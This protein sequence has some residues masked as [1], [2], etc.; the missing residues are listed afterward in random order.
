MCFRAVSPGICPLNKINIRQQS[1]DIDAADDLVTKPRR[2]GL[3]K[4]L[5]FKSRHSKLNSED[6]IEV[7]HK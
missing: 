3:K 1:N 2:L 4:I 6:F 7:T 5:P